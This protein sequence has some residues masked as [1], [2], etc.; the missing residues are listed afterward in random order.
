MRKERNPSKDTEVILVSDYPRIV[1]E[2]SVTHPGMWDVFVDGIRRYIRKTKKGAISTAKRI[3]N[4]PGILSGVAT[5]LGIGAGLETA[6]RV[7]GRVG[8]PDGVYLFFDVSTGKMVDAIDARKFKGTTPKRVAEDFER[9]IGTQIQVVFQPKQVGKRVVG[10]I[11][12]GVGNPPK[13]YSKKFYIQ[14]QSIKPMGFGP[15]TTETAVYDG[16]KFRQDRDYT[17]PYKEF[18]GD[19]HTYRMEDGHLPEYQPRSSGRDLIDNMKSMGIR[20]AVRLSSNNPA[21][22][23]H[24]GFGEA[25]AEQLAEEF[26]GRQPLDEVYVEEEEEYR[27]DLTKLGDLKELEILDRKGKYTI[28]I[29]LDTGTE[30]ASTPDGKQLIVIGDVRGLDLDRLEVSRAE[31]QKDLVEIGPIY[32][33]TYFTD[34]H[35]LSGPKYQKDGCEYWHQFGEN[36]GNRPSLV[37]DKLNGKLLVVGGSYRVKDVGIVD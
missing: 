19:N 5:G 1:V 26:H 20:R 35:H 18:I 22:L 4:N 37:Y 13:I 11:G 16:A 28:P 8:N 31:Q 7:A 17:K 30:L 25:T 12:K 23:N 33:V 36:S 21:L 3:A 34:K 27:S 10:R 24:L 14:T 6:R 32:T 29:Q 2:P 9:K 15:W